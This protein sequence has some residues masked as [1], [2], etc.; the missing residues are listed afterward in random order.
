MTAASTSSLWDRLPPEIQ[1]QIL[2]HTD[3]L[4]R[5]LN[6]ILTPEEI[7]QYGIEIWK[8]AFKYD[9]QGDLAILPQNKLP[10]IRDGLNLVHSK[11]M[12]NRLCISRPDLTGL[13]SL[14]E[15]L[16]RSYLWTWMFPSKEIWSALSMFS[17]TIYNCYSWNSAMIHIPMMLFWMEEINQL[18]AIIKTTEDKIKLITIAA[19]FGYSR[20]LKHLLDDLPSMLSN[21]T[22]FRPMGE[23]YSFIL[24][25]AAAGGNIVVFDN[26]YRLDGV[27]PTAF[28]NQ[29]FRFACQFGQ[30]EIVERFLALNPVG[31]NAADAGN[32]A[33][34]A[35]SQGGYTDIVRT[36]LKMGEVLIAGITVALNN[37]ALKGHAD[38]VKL[39]LEV[40]GV[41]ANTEMVYQT[42]SNA[43]VCGH[44][45][46]VDLL[47]N[48][49]GVDAIVDYKYMVRNALSSGRANVAK[50]LLDFGLHK[51]RFL[52]ADLRDF[53]IRA[54]D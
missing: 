37:A 15:I 4:T 20:L 14:V 11:A 51:E 41:N 52:A 16:D 6:G 7:Y 48:V 18:M 54:S 29:P 46:V 12:Y 22:R 5:Y 43:A 17:S 10:T 2:L 53:L 32:A 50:V 19:L 39:L 25:A 24:A 23:L 49:Q 21:E 27:N 34:S 35:A 36:L 30:L 28:Y 42:L 38:V 40:K 9:W 44:A 47:L 31:F 1:H 3:Y 26:V 8:T 45:N 33:I 13:N